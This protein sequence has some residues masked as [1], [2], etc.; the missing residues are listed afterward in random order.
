VAQA[1]EAVIL[2]KKKIEMMLID[3]R[4]DVEAGKLIK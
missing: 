3:F 4:A 1:L 2:E